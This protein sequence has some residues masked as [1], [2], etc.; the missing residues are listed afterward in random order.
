MKTKNKCSKTKISEIQF[1]RAASDK[2]ACLER[3]GVF[4]VAC[5]Y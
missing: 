2:H 5:L 1:Q 4:G 3:Y